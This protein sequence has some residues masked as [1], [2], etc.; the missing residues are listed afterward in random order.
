MIEVT[1]AVADAIGSS[2]TALRLSPAN[3]LNDI[4]EDDHRATYPLVLSALDDLGLAYLHI[5][6]TRDPE[7]TPLLRRA[8]SGAFMLNPATPGGRTGPEHLDLVAAGAADLISFGQLFIANPDLP[9]RLLLDAPL[10]EP[11]MRKAYGGD[12]HGYT[13]YPA[14]AE[15]IAA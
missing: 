3:P 5:L 1:R 4:V 12:H 14:L 10:A 8:W 7:L 11:D 9:R 6:E 13:D 2:R 15:P